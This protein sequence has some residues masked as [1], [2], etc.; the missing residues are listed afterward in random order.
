MVDVPLDIYV[1]TLARAAAMASQ[2]PHSFKESI[3]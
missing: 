3:M 2:K 1:S